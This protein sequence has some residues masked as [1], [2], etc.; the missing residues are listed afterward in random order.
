MRAFAID[1]FGEPGSLRVLPTPTIGVDEMLVHVRAAG[2]NPIDWKIRDGLKAIEDVRFPLIHGQDG[3]GIVMQVGPHVT[4]YA[5]G[6]EVYGDFW[7]AGAFAEYV[8]ASTSAQ[9]CILLTRRPKG[10]SPAWTGNG[11]F[12]PFHRRASWRTYQTLS[13][14]SMKTHAAAPAKRQATVVA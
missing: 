9:E 7:F 13:V 3:A 12:H 4:R 11:T 10:S 6:D 2:V 5:V 1:R 8:L 14:E